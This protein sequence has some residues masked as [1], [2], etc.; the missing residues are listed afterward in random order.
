MGVELDTAAYGVWAQTVDELMSYRYLGCRSV[1]GEGFDAVGRMRVRSD[2]RSGDGLLAAPVAIA[3]LDTA[4]I[5][6]DRHW[7]LALTHVAVHLAGPAPGVGAIEVHGSLTR[8]SRS[9]VF[10]EARIVDADHPGR[11][12]GVG[13]ADWTVIAPTGSGFEYIDPGAGVPDSPDLPPLAAAY[14]AQRRDDGRYVIEA[15]TPK[16]GGLMLHHGPILVTAEAAARDA[17]GP[18]ARVDSLDLRIVKAGRKGPF[19]TSA[20]VAADAGGSVLVRTRMHRDGDEN[21]V[22]ATAVVRA[23]RG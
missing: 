19:V 21:N 7:Q 23:T 12:L 15:L 10:T 13:T 17:A 6:V 1:L 9:Q 2:M 20:T 18:A 11:V 5:A 14:G 22:V 3:M 4:G 16:L 8:Q